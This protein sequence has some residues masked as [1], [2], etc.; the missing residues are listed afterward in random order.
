ML[1]HDDLYIVFTVLFGIIQTKAK[2]LSFFLLFFLF[3][4]P[5]K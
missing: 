5:K 3:A 1:I 2:F 4:A